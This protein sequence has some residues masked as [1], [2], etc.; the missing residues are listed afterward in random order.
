M[1]IRRLYVQLHSVADH[2]AWDNILNGRDIMPRIRCCVG[3]HCR[4]RNQ[5]SASHREHF[6]WL[7]CCIAR[8]LLLRVSDACC[9]PGVSCVCAP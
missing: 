1:V 6:M 9:T 7:R 3:C 8:L 5:A 4:L 2:A